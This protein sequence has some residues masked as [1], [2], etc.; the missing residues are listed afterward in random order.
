MVVQ[1]SL[2]ETDELFE[3]RL[4]AWQFSKATTTGVGAAITDMEA[5]RLEERSGKTYAGDV[6]D[7]TEHGKAQTA[8]VSLF[9]PSKCCSPRTTKIIDSK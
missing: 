2:E 5:H 6:A 7:D 8:E 4:W 9:Y 3:L 1:R